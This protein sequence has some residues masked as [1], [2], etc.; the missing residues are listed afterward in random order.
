MTTS[1]ASL[2]HLSETAR[3]RGSSDDGRAVVAGAL[4][5]PAAVVP[6]A[7]PA[8]VPLNAAPTTVPP[9]AAPA[10]VAPI[11]PAITAAAGDRSRFP[12]FLA[13]FEF[14]YLIHVRVNSDP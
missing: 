7:A 12:R 13:E 14:S 6:N 3:T 10:T 5:V 4:S 8:T 2:A 9:N 11:G 1:A